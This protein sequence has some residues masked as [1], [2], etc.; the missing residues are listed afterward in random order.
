MFYL[1]AY[2]NFLPKGYAPV[3]TSSEMCL[4]NSRVRTYI[5]QWQAAYDKLGEYVWKEEPSTLSYYFGIPYDYE[6][7]FEAT[8]LMFAFEV[9]KDREVMTLTK[10]TPSASE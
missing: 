5:P 6:H 10:A 2:V 3:S 9:Y 1:F 4:V 8:P 7:D